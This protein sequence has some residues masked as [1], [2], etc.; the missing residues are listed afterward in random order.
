MPLQLPIKALLILLLHFMLFLFIHLLN[1][2]TTLFLLLNILI[3]YLIF[4]IFNL[5]NKVAI[6]TVLGLD[7][8]SGLILN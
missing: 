5:T 2:P 8:L 4:V 3:R 6:L 7:L 1:S